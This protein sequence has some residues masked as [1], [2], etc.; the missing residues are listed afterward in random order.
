[1]VTPSPYGERYRLTMFENRILSKVFGPT[2]KYRRL[3]KIA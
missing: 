3:K 2:R 1:V